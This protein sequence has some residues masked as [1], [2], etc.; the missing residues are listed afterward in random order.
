M[1]QF[2]IRIV[3]DTDPVNPRKDYY[4]PATMVCW[5]PRYDLG[6][7]HHFND[8]DDLAEWAKD[9]D[10]FTLPLY[11]YDH[12][13]ITMSTGAFQCPWDSGQVG[14]IYISREDAKR[15]YGDVSNDR[16]YDLL[17]GEVDTY[18]QYLRG[19]VWGYE[20]LAPDGECVDSCWGFF[21]SGYCREE[22]ERTKA[23]H[24]QEAR[25]AHWER[26]KGWIRGKVGLQ[27]RVAFQA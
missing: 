9:K 1:G 5:H 21:G 16:I 22:A 2:T 7:D 26:L 6:D 18:D 10:L 19:D 15:E 24:E 14:Y 23:W 20:I 13:G 25:K 17:R 8:V 12:G 3:Q 4:N 27:Y 11:L